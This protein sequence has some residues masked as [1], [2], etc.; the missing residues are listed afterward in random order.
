MGQRVQSNCFLAQGITAV[1]F[2]LQDA[3]HR[4]GAPYSQ[5]LDRG[6]AAFGKQLR[7]CHGRV[8]IEV[9]IIN[10]AYHISF[11]LDD[12]PFVALISEERPI[13]VDTQPLRSP[14][15]E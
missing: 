6:D 11:F 13:W 14:A 4:A 5:T 7:D 1:F 12:L 8:A 9:Q 2:I 10:G 15:F 3:E